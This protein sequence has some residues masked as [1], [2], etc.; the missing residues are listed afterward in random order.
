MGPPGDGVPSGWARACGAPRGGGPAGRAWCEG[1]E[2]SLRDRD[3]LRGDALGWRGAAAAEGPGLRGAG[4]LVQAAALPGPGPRP[5]GCLGRRSAATADTGGFCSWSLRDEGR[6][7][8]A[9]EKRRAK[10]KG[11]TLSDSL[12]TEPWSPASSELG[13]AVEPMAQVEK[14]GP[15]LRPPGQDL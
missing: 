8:K 12:S 4:G 13:E 5:G 14:P 2:L 10:K 9:R 7:Q 3:W 6:G 1:E 15:M 11:E